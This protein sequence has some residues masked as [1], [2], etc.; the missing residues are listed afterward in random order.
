MKVKRKILLTFFII[1]LLFI[2]SLCGIGLYF[3]HHPALVKTFIEKSIARTTHTSFKIE[4]LS[5]SLKPLSIRAEGILFEPGKDHRGFH[6]EIPELTADMTL[7]GAFGNKSLTFKKLEIAGFSCRGSHDMI[8]PKIESKTKTPS[9]I[10]SVVKRLAAFFLFRDIRFQAAQISNGHILAQTEEQTVRISNINAHLN[11]DHLVEISCGALFLWPSREIRFTAP[12]LLIT[13]DR[14]I[15]LVNPEMRCHLTGKEADFQSPDANVKSMGV[16]AK[17]IFNRTQKSL[18]IDLADIHFNDIFLNNPDASVRKIEA[19]AKLIYNHNLKKVIF[20]PLHVLFRGAVL[21]QASETEISPL[22][23]NLKTQGFFDLGKTEL[24]VAGFDLTVFDVAGFQG[25]I[26]AGLGTETFFRLELSDGRFL[27]EKALPLVPLRLR[28]QLKPVTLSGPVLFH[29]IINGVKQEKAWELDCDL[30]ARLKGNRVSYAAEEMKM[31]SNISA[32]IRAQGKFPD[33]KIAVRMNGYK[34]VFSGKGMVLKPSTVG[35]S[36]SGKYPIFEIEE[37]KANVPRASVKTGEKDILIDDIRLDIRKGTFDAKK[38]SIHVPEIRLESSLLKNLL[39]ALRFEGERLSVAIQGKQTNIMESARALNLVPEGW[40]ISGIDSIQIRANQKQKETWSFISEIG[41]QEVGFENRESSCAGEK[42]SLNA[43][44]AGEIDLK[45]TFIAAKAS[46]EV[47]GGEALYDRFY[48]NLNSNAFFCSCDAAYNLSKKFLQLSRL[49][50]GVKNILAL[51]MN[52]NILHGPGNQRISLSL[53]IPKTSLKPVFDHFV[54]EPF[55]T[56]KP[57]LATLEIGGEISADLKL[58]G[59]GKDLMATGNFLWH[60]GELSL[61]ENDVSFRGIELYLPVWY[62]TQKGGKVTDK[63]K[64]NLSVR[65]MKLP[66][67]P[68]QPLILKL[69]A[70]PNSLSIKAPTVIRIPGGSVRI[71]PLAGKDIFGTQPSINTSLTM[72]SVEIQPLLSGIWK[73]PVTGTINGK[74]DPI[75][76][77]GGT[78][79]TRGN[80]KAGVFEGEIILSDFG[81]SGMFTSTPVFRMSARMNALRLAGMTGGTSFGKIEGVLDGYVRDLEVAYGQPQK[82]DL[83]LE[84][85]RTK[86]VSQKISVK[87]VDNIARIGGGQSP[88]VGLAGGFAT[89]FKE[90][91]YKKI[92]VRASLQNDVFRV[93][94]TIREGGKEYIIKRGSFS[95]VDI[96]NQN[97][98]NRASFKDMVKR[99]KRVTATSGGP[100]IK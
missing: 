46:F 52:G 56:E 85:V 9:L 88:F 96:V 86:G 75:H 92:G 43:K 51:N 83:L 40:Q 70:G 91:P 65:A 100:V 42:I 27:P 17:I 6:L 94:G 15:S 3:Y 57:V 66:M 64:G 39:L 72:N 8:L 54:L 7:E 98:D 62:R 34:T 95:G 33:I 67:L 58:S 97:P 55:Q 5:Y 49:R 38:R 45:K 41:L 24:D 35:L 73:Q 14:A 93:N 82:F 99:I 68:E 36:F 11:T 19:K 50:L 69:D 79:T 4:K 32:E 2:A 76:V 78:L 13:T 77:K 30:Q 18:A 89:F 60:D 90:F 44:I 74:L 37:L 25:K 47:N 20:E 71:G 26:H 23:L 84:T 63:A 29:G 81:A 28:A 12:H 87:A 1:V 53:N 31:S 80:I 48:L 16:M 59:I 22:N 61:T 10:V 21:K